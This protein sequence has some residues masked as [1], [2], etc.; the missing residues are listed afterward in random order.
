MPLISVEQAI[1]DIQSGRFVV[2]VDDEDRENEGDFVM[3]AVHVTADSI[4]F[5]AKHGRGLICVPMRAERLKE[6]DLELMVTNNTARH[7]TAF[8]V[9]V[10]VNNGG[11]GIS[12][13]DR[14]E[15]VRVLVDEATRPA[16]LARPGHMFPLRAEDGGVLVRVGQTEASVDLARMAGL[17]PAAVVCEIMNEDGSMARMPELEKVGAEH[18]IGIVSVAQIVAYRLEHER[19][20]ERVAEARLPT[21]YGEARAVAF[22]SEVDAAEHVALVFGDVATTDPVLVRVHSECLTGD[23]FGSVRCDCGLQRDM[24]IKA[25]A[26]EGCGVF[27]YMRQEGRGIG[28]HNKIRAYA[29]QD[30]G[31]DTVEA[32]AQLGFPPDLRHYGIGAQILVNL[33]VQNMRLL[34]NNPKKVVGLESYGLNL[35]ERVPI[36]VE[37]NPENI[38][39]LETKRDKLG[40][41]LDTLESP[42]AATSPQ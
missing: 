23:V 8:T 30:G 35:V 15:T 38:H 5:M 3:A 22:K 25:I 16:D 18:G 17:K 7:S 40:H 31:A 9:S 14:A 1:E 42:P 20:V 2:I 26:E 24:A 33:G 19:L 28:L 32:N 4:N 34:T 21:Q 13:T 6:L 39:Y 41:L 27:L 11:T 12:A 10:D 37:V 29:L 36:E